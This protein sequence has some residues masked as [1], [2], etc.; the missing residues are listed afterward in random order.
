MPQALIIVESPTKAR[1]IQNYLGREFAV[2]AS[3]GHVKDL[4]TNELGIDIDKSFK[5]KYLLIKGKRKVMTELKSLAKQVERIYLAVD[6]DREGEAIGWHI[7]NELQ[8]LNPNIF[9]IRLHE[10]TRRSVL[11]A[12]NHPGELDVAL[13]ESQMARRILD[14]LVGY[15]I[16]PLLWR[17]VRQGLSAGR[18][19]SVALRL[20]VE[21]ERE[22][23]AFIPREYWEVMGQFKSGDSDAFT[24]KLARIGDKKA[25]ISN[26]AEADVVLADLAKAR[27]DISLVESKEVK[28]RSQPPYI[29]SRLQQDGW[30]FFKFP[31]KK[32]MSVAQRLY[33]GI[34]A[35]DEAGAVGLITYMRTDSVRVSDEAIDAARGF[36]KEAYGDAYAPPKPNAYK[37]KK[38][39]Q[40]A[41]EAI[42]PVSMEYP[43]ERVK[44]HLSGEEFKLYSIIWKRFVASQ[45]AAARF[46]QSN[47]EVSADQRYHFRTTGMIP[48]FD[49]YT[50]VYKKEDE[51]GEEAKKLPAVTQGAAVDAEAITPEQKFTEPKARF[52]ESTLIR[53]LEERGIG[54]PSTYA[55][56]VSTLL[57]KEYVARDK[58]RFVPSE[59]G[60]YTSDVLVE[61]FP[62]EMEVGFTA[63][64]EESLDQVEEGKVEWHHLLEQ[65]YANF[66]ITLEKAS[67]KEGEPGAMRNLKKLAEETGIVCER[68]NEGHMQVKLGRNGPFLGCS[69][70]PDCKNTRDYERDEKGVIK[71][72]ERGGPTGTCPEC[73]G[74]L[75]AKRG[76]YGEFEACAN[77]PECTFTRPL[78]TGMD[79]PMENCEGTLVQRRSRRGRTFYGC[80]KYPD[81]TFTMPGEP[82]K[83]ECPSC[84]FALLSRR[85]RRR[86]EQL[87]CPNEKCGEVIPA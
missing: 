2:R 79:C 69:K 30:R 8:K 51:E 66:A 58:G 5:P 57:D 73:E 83:Q 4:P 11:D 85:K 61:S 25:V 1:T 43:P 56:I 10:I 52:T 50:R 65:F 70:Y 28:R 37:N 7:S 62:K 32:T 55:T 24:A 54:R 26:Q 15:Q 71:Q 18:V 60:G 84:G 64:M 22:I 82:V 17:R 9:R 6:P 33:E 16:S 77:Y 53:E 40:D 21:R 68:C 45:M 38:S 23:R 12:L 87:V 72:V 78:S 36:I 42:R 39:A 35:G 80:T 74:A 75:V 81:C 14:R 63:S 47:I 13:V 19:Q 49:G 67:G 59:L 34:N 27:Y 3:M 20:I 48:V 31:A 41:H 46:A 44:A 29:T 76:R 86:G